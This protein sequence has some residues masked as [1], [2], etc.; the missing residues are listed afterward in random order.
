MLKNYLIFVF[1]FLLLLS[2]S[3]GQRPDDHDKGQQRLAE[4]DSHDDA[5]GGDGGD[6]G[7]H[8]IAIVTKELEDFIQEKMK[9]WHVPG[10]AIA[11]IEGDKSWYKVRYSSSCDTAMQQ[12]RSRQLLS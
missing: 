2:I 11:I 1:L 10:L 9:R 5:S 7:R 12:R 4:A 8:N 6:G 3:L